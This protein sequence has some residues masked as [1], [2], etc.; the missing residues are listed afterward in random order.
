[1][2]VFAVALA[3]LVG[4]VAAVNG[5][6]AWDKRTHERRIRAAVTGFGAGQVLADYRDTDE[7]RFQRARLAVIPHPRLVAFGSSR[8]QPLSTEMV[9][10]A[11]GEFY[12]AGLSGGTVEDFIV[13]WSVLKANGRV[14][15]AALFAIDQWQFNRMHEQVRWLEWAV[16]VNR[17]V[18]ASGGDARL[19]GL[20]VDA[21]LYTWL[22][23]KELAR[24]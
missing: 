12:N 20:P 15:E 4:L 2:R 5:L 7:R 22:Q 11:P 13:L 6:A 16:E 10:L 9:G 18:E 17:F 21:A 1:M 3:L 24:A 8:M 19:F 14:P 23:A